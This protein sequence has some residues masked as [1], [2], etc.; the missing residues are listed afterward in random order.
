MT[1]RLSRRTVLATG[2]ASLAAGLGPSPVSGQEAPH[3]FMV[4]PRDQAATERGFRDYF[5]RRGI[6]IRYTLRNTGGDAGRLRE[7][8]AEIRATAPDLVYTWGTPTTLGVVGSWDQI[9]P[10]R[11]ITDIP[12]VFTT[13]TAPVGSRVGPSRERPGRNVTGT[14]HIPPLE[15]QINTVQAYRSIARLGVIYNP[16]ERNSVF[17]VESL[18][19]LL[20]SRGITLIERPVPLNGNGQPSQEAVPGL[21]EEVA[22]AGAD[23]LYIGP[24]TFVAVTAREPLTT[25]A[26]EARLPTFSATETIVRRSRALFGLFSNGISVGRFTAFKAEQILVGGVSPQDIPVETLRRFTLLINMP[27]AR[28]I[29]AY[30]PLALLDLAEIVDS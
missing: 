29:E 24:D 28:Q 23:F 25:A 12:V 8:I 7:V 20:P 22:D 19:T 9:D 5:E 11:H 13:V 21:V 15:V 27:V 18:R 14:S 4:L 1:L 6:A 30:P 2:A 17:T 26:I 10:T 16:I 3:V